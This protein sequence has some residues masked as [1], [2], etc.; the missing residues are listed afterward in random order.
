MNTVTVT[1]Y[2]NTRVTMDVKLQDGFIISLFFLLSPIYC[3]Q[4]RFVQI[5]FEKKIFEKN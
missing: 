5:I 2:L 4:D 3:S 1:L